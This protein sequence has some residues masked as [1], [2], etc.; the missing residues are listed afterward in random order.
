M[1]L[2]KIT[3]TVVEKLQPGEWLWD[4]DHR[5]V[6][7]GFGAR[8]QVRGVF[9]Y[10]RYRLEGEQ[11]MMSIGRHGSPFTP[12]TARNEA[13]RLLGSVAAGIDPFKQEKVHSV[14]VFATE[15]LRYLENKKAAMKHLSWREVERHL[16][17]HAKPLHQ[18]KLSEIKRLNVAPVLNEIELERGPVARNN[19]R[20]S[21]SAFFA[22]AITEGL[23]ETNPVSGTAK[24]NGIRSRDRVLTEAELAEVW[25]TLEIGQF[26]DIMQLLVLTGQRRNE[27][28]GLRWSEVDFERGLIVLQPE[29]T[30][31]KRSHELP[32]SNAAQAI[33]ERQRRRKNDDNSPRD[34]V[35]GRDQGGFSGWSVAKGRLD[36]HLL[37]ARREVDPKAKPMLDWRLHDLRRTAATVM[38][39]KL[40]VL[41]HIVE[42]VLNHVSGHK[43]GVAGIYNRARYEAEMREALERWGE[44]VEAITSRTSNVRQSA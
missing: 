39:D 16:M 27:I 33:L 41:P 44:H 6:V 18:L 7:K 28:G 26:G 21:L 35:F 30:K 8:R 20:S 4:A 3:K 40:G 38:A 32:L 12:D 36:Q 23:I 43:G 5:E 37:A 1:A 24:A 2:G 19:T 31:N 15:A 13:K 29:R 22:W 25:T 42:A 9:Y 17:N 10:L 11:R 14:R 34:L